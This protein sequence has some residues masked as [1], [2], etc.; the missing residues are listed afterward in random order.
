MGSLYLH[1]P[2]CLTKCH[3]C[4]FSSFAAAAELFEPYVEAIKK[5]IS[6]LA[7]KTGSTVID[8]LFI[9]GGTPTVL[10]PLLLTTIL[11][12]CR[13]LFLFSSGAEVSVEANP[14]TIDKRYLAMLLEAGVNRISFGVQ[15]FNDHE[16]K[17]LGRVHNRQG[18][19]QAV[20]DARSCGFTNIS[21][22]LMYGLPGQTASTWKK[23]LEDGIGLSPN[24]L[25]LYQ[26]TLEPETPFNDLFIRKKLFLPT[27][28]EVLQMDGITKDICR[29]SGLHKY[30]IS[31]YAVN[32]YECR[33]NINYWLNQEYIAAGA[34]AVSFMKGV[35]ERRVAA[36]QDYISL[37]DRNETV[38]IEKECLSPDDSFRETVIMGLR[39]NRGVSR[40]TLLLRY[41]IDVEKYYGEILAKLVGQGLV[42]LTDSHLRITE[43]GNPFSNMIMADLV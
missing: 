25:S 12:H 11:N 38:V 9:G 18:A 2:F 33:H 6:I 32:G 28:D 14:G 34:S 22:D 21:L 8:T 23:S 10:P 24:H 4:S 36:P 42:E 43:K 7:S 5:E 35:R 39:M 37:F 17:V 26:L 31:N 3:Y 29:E 20:N 16:L 15:S 27:E 41:G 19:N 13:E 40:E 1:I 30:E